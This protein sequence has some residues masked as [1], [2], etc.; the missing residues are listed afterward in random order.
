MDRLTPEEI[1][2]LVNDDELVEK[3][4]LLNMY[5]VCEQVKIIETKRKCEVCNETKPIINFQR[6]VSSGY[7]YNQCVKC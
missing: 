4:D 5:S 3:Y 6:N 2:L 1:Y 7:I